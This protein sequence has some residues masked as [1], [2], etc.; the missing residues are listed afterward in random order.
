MS[1]KEN[2]ITEVYTGAYASGKSEI[3]INR[4]LDIHKNNIPVVLVDLDTVEPAYTLRPIKEKLETYG[5]KVITQENYFGLGET[6]NVLTSQQINCL[7]NP[8]NL[9]IDVGYGAGGLDILEIITNIEKEKNLNIYIVINTFKPETST[10]DDIVQY[11]N[12]T[13]GKT[14]YVWKKFAGIISNSH[15]GSDTTK[16]DILSGLIKTEKA[17]EI[18]G[19]PIFAVSAD[20]KFLPDFE[21]KNIEGI[22]VWFLKRFMPEALW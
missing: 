19:I 8:E 15:I 17:S 12:W 1:K 16:E 9:V 7:H 18:T 22:P 21:N 13:Q 5:I 11:I 10:V 4:A 3:S 20:E 6:G 2:R 14:P